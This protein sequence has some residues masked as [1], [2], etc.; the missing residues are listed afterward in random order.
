[1]EIEK[2]KDEIRWTDGER[3]TADGESAYGGRTDGRQ[4]NGWRTDGRQMN[5]WRTYGERQRAENRVITSNDVSM[6]G[7]G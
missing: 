7:E 2:S 5:G 3:R 4:M 1:M 6:E